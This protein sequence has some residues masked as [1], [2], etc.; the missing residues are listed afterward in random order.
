MDVDTRNA[1][2]SSQKRFISKHL[3]SAASFF[4][5]ENMNGPLDVLLVVRW[6]GEG[7]VVI[8]LEVTANL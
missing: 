4:G 1:E 8:K 7:F 3:P 2:I 6:Y 5:I